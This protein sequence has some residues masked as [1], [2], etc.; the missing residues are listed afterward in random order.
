MM[1]Q[2]NL[3]VTVPA[4][5]LVPIQKYQGIIPRIILGTSGFYDD[6]SAVRFHVHIP[7]HQ[8]CW[9][10]ESGRGSGGRVCIHNHLEVGVGF[11]ESDLLLL[12]ICVHKIVPSVL[13]HPKFTPVVFLLEDIKPEK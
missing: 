5:N 6:Y 1:V 12:C 4:A 10:A 2:L 8:Q 3:Q 9:C 13:H 7:R 11:Y